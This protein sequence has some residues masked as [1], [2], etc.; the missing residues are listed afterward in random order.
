MIELFILKIVLILQVA[1]TYHSTAAPSFDGDV[2]AFWV[3]LLA[4]V[5][6]PA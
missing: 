4:G 5:T 1:F 6:G 3:R 2:Q